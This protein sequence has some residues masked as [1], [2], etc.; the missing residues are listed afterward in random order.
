MGSSW[1][2]CQDIGRR[3]AA[4]V[5]GMMNMIGNL[6]G[7]VAS[8]MSGYVLARAVV[9]DTLQEAIADCEKDPVHKCKVLYAMAQIHRDELSDDDQAVALYEEALDC[10]PTH[11]E[12]FERITSLQLKTLENRL[13]ATVEFW[14]EAAEVRDFDGLKTIW[15]KSVSLAKE[16]TEKLYAN[17]QEVFSL[18]V[19]TSEALG[20]LTKG[21]IE[22]ANDTFNKQVN[23]AKKA[24]K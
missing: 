2:T 1:A 16:T 8:Y 4:I 12:G 20:Q 7:T 22:N 21:S 9:C 3:Y 24:G 5:A 11:L 13:A 6:G 10:N 17:G 15:P 18:A 14:S 23:V 19:K